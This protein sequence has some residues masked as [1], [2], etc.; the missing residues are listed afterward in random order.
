MWNAIQ[1]FANSGCSEVHFG[2]TSRNDEGLSRFKRSWGCNSETLLYFRQSLS[3]GKWDPANHHVSESHP[4]I[5]GH[6]PIGLNRFAG[7]LIY[8]HLD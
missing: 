4:M 5:F 7:H 1:H 6:L 2:R 8:P 3:T